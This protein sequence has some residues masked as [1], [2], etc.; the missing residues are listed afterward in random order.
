[1]AEEPVRHGPRRKMYASTTARTASDGRHEG[2]ILTI[3]RDRGPTSR[4]GLAEITGLSPTTISKVVAPLVDRGVLREGT[5]EA[6]AVGRPAVTLT[7]VPEAVTVCGAQIGVGVVRVALADALSR[8]RAVESITFDPAMP[9]EDVITLIAD[10]LA[11]LLAADRG[12][13]CVGVGIGVPGPV[14]R[15]QRTVLVSTN[16]GWRDVPVADLVEARLRLPVVV[17]HNVRSMALAEARYGDHQS[18]SLALVY[19]RTG[20]GLGVVVADQAFQG[21]TGGESYLGHT[22]A[23]EN[24][25]LCTCGARGCLDT[26]VAEPYLRRM[27]AG[28]PGGSTAA[29]DDNPLITLRGLAAAGNSGAI[30][31]EDEV[32]NR[33]AAA[34]GNVVNLFAPKLVLV[35]GILSTVP[36]PVL[37]ILRVRVR[38]RLFPLLRET[39]TLERASGSDDAIVRGAAAAA[40]ELLHYG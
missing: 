29:G 30:A 3:L 26:V 36:D 17:E 8:V 31:L 23:V 12:A 39:F 28:L 21:G 9:A 1:M 15:A 10:R 14:D 5:V 37:D 34:L 7:P 35:G 13:P 20:V 32:I 33:L 24:G 11:A 25:E 22:R 16:L 19:V 18:H 4:T 2:R 40:L 27:L 6:R 38:D